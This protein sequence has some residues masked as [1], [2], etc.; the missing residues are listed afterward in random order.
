M[1]IKTQS[2]VFV[3]HFSEGVAQEASLRTLLFQF[4][5]IFITSFHPKLAITEFPEE[6]FPQLWGVGDVCIHSVCPCLPL[7]LLQALDKQPTEALP[8]VPGACHQPAN[9]ADARSC[10][11]LPEDAAQ[12]ISLTLCQPDLPCCLLPLWSD[13]FCCRLFVLVFGSSSALWLNRSNI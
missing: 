9:P 7:S 12:D 1:S 3:I 2:Q 13:L 5:I 4:H 11:A 6:G 10:L 8:A